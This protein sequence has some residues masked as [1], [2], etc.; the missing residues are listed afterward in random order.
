MRSRMRESAS[1]D[2][3][4]PQGSNPLGP[5]G[6]EL[7]APATGQAR[8]GNARMVDRTVAQAGPG[9]ES[10]SNDSVYC[11]TLRQDTVAIKDGK[12]QGQGVEA[13]LGAI[14]A[15]HENDGSRSAAKHAAEPA[16]R[17]VHD[18]FDG[19]V[20]REQ[21]GKD[22]DVGCSHNRSADAFLVPRVLRV[23]QVERERT[24][25]QA[26]GELA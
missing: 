1:T 5:P 20:G 24:L 14:G 17:G 9:W 15:G 19:E 13:R 12:G 7:A 21:V 11:I 23:G 10:A 8:G 4:E 16:V 18:R 22:H 2:L 25:D 3:R 26:G 6:P